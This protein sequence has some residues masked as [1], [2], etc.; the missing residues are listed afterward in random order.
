MDE[1]FLV[2]P[3]HEDDNPSLDIN[4]K[5]GVGFCFGCHKKI[6]IKEEVNDG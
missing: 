1:I 4:L 3:Y 2:C 5:T 6:K